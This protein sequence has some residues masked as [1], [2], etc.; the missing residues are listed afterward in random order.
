MNAVVCGL[1][2]GL[3][4]AGLSEGL[5]RCWGSRPM[6]AFWKLL[7]L[8]AALRVVWV[9]GLLGGVLATGIL[10]GKLF[11]VALLSSYFIAQML[12]ALRHRNLIRSR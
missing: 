9:L 2:G 12:E 4:T 5:L 11:T 7:L 1:L 6:N 8:G 10:D 3:A